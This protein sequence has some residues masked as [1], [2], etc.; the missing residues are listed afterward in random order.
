MPFFKPGQE[1]RDRR[2]ARVE[3]WVWVFVYGGLLALVLGLFMVRQQDGSGVLL[4]VLG[5]IATAVGALL[6]YLR[7]RMPPS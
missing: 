6:L 4:M 5:G 1:A 2:V 3:T 7:S